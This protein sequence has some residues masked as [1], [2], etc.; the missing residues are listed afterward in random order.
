MHSA[1]TNTSFYWHD[2][3]TFGINPA[4][5][6]PAQFAGIRTDSEL[7]IIGEPLELYCK[8]PTDYLPQPQAC[9]ITGITPQKANRLGLPESE[10]IQRIHQ[11]FSQPGSCIIGYNNI[12]FDDEVTRNLLYRNFYDPYT[13]SYQKGNSRWDLLDVVRAC[14]ALRPDGIEWPTDEETGDPVFKLERLSAANGLEHANAHDAVSDVMVTIEFARLIRKAQ[15][16][17]FDYLFK[18]RGKKEVSELMDMQSLKPFVH[19]S[20]MIPAAQGCVTWMSAVGRHPLQQNAII[21]VNLA[22]D[23]TPLIE[24]NVEELKAAL[25]T[26]RQ[27]RA[28]DHPEVPVKLIHTNKCP[29]VAPAST[30]S[31]ERA[32]ELGINRAQCRTSL[33][34]LRDNLTLI[35]TKLTELYDEGYETPDHQDPDRM[36]YSGG[37]FSAQDKQQFAIIHRLTPEAL[38]EQAFEFQDPRLKEMLFR[39]RARNYPYTLKESELARWQSHRQDYFEQHSQPFILELENQLQQYTDDEHKSGVLKALYHYAEGL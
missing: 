13:Y 34:L 9:L 18:Q 33:N 4:T 32:E 28:E 16:R 17:L 14:Y 24:L 20:G 7:N 2:Y 23:I 30:L 36:I 5:D 37:F 25:Y 35:R 21:C 38:A 11:E 8:V 12:R 1:Q 22:K 39:Y 31:E 3:E 19:V 29:V 6:R 15:P 10:F 27:D 26:P